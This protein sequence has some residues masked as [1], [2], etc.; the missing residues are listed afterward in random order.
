MYISLLTIFKESF[1]KKTQFLNSLLP[2]LTR[3]D[4]CHKQRL[5]KIISAW[6]KFHKASNIDQLISRNFQSYKPRITD[7]VRN[8]QN[9]ISRV[10]NVAIYAPLQL[11]GKKKTAYSSSSS[12]WSG[13]QSTTTPGWSTMTLMASVTRTKMFSLS[14]SSRWSRYFWLLK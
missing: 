10:L 9:D 13:L 12:L 8:V 2:I 14:T 11:W 4:I 5:C 7:T 1:D 3:P 6:V